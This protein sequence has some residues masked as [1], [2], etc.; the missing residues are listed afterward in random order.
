MHSIRELPDG[1]A[2]FFENY[3]LMYGLSREAAERQRD[4]FNQR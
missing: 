2:L 1:W 3:P 4:I